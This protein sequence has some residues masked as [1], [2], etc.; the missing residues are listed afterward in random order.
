MSDFLQLMFFLSRRESQSINFSISYSYQGPHR[1]KNISLAP[2]TVALVES[3]CT[4]P[5]RI[6][7]KQGSFFYQIQSACEGNGSLRLL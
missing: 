5:L 2:G 7:N 3:W 6:R 1:A 4:K